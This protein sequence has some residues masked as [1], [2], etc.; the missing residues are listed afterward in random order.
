MATHSRFVVTFTPMPGVD[1]V[2]ALRSLVKAAARR[3][4]LIAVDAREA[5]APDFSTQFA[6]AFT[7]L[8]HDV[9]RRA[10]RNSPHPP[11]RKSAP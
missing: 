5:A 8:R 11:Q 2:R 6:S 10:A 4:G 3:Y 7:K 9:A 1:G